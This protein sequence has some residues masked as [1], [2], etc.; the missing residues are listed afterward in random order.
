M[1]ESKCPKCDATEFEMT[2]ANIKNLGNEFK[3]IQCA[4]CGAV[5]NAFSSF[6]PESAHNSLVSKI[7][8]VAKL[9]ETIMQK[10][11]QIQNDIVTL[12]LKS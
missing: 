2:T 3:F 9:S 1:S 7:N 5:I 6:N 11:L 10:I 8:Q 4:S 12:R